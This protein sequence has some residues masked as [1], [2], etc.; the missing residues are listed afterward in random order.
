MNQNILQKAIEELKKEQ[1]KIDYVLG[2][3]ETFAELTTPIFTTK[4]GIVKKIHSLV[5]T[6]ENGLVHQG[7]E[8]GCYPNCQA[9]MKKIQPQDEAATLDAKAR[10]AI[11]HV[12]ALNNEPQ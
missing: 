11:E 6:V 7:N 9:C 2:M 5:G 3:L 1:P 12:K 10:A 4:E 8:F